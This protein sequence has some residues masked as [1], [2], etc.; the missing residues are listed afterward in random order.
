MAPELCRL[1]ATPDHALDAFIQHKYNPRLAE[2]NDLVANKKNQEKLVGRMRDAMNETAYHTDV[3]AQ[4]AKRVEKT[5][6][7]QTQCSEEELLNAA[8]AVVT[9]AEIREKIR[10][11]RVEPNDRTMG[12][13]PIAPENGDIV[14]IR[15]NTGG[16][17]WAVDWRMRGIVLKSGVL[18]DGITLYAVCFLEPDDDTVEYRLVMADNMLV[19]VPV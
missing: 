8:K 17:S 18:S 5:R 16:R 7:E 15:E 13:R 12:P 4:L 9:E 6:L 10:A 2:K 1:G 19:H 14:W 11:G 3:M